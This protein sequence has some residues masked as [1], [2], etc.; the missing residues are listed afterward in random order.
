MNFNEWIESEEGKTSS[1][2]ITLNL[3][4]KQ[5]Q[6]LKNRLYRSFCAGIRSGVK[7]EKRRIREELLKLLGLQ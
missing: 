1:D 4:P 5:S 2:P 7:V 3:D 6:F